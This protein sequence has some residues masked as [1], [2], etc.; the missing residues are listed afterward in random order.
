MNGGIYTQ[1]FWI[2]QIGLGSLLPL[3]L[4][5]GPTGKSRASIATASVLVILGGLAQVYVIVI[6]GQAY[7]IDIYPG[8][9]VLSSSFFDGQVNAYNPTLPEFL[10]G[11]SGFAITL[12][13]TAIAVK[14]LRFLPESLGDEAVTTEEQ[15]EAEAAKAHA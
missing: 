10:L 1:L 13:A 12:V 3:A 11:L 6:G 14:V 15:E 7:P 4:L 9:E 8:Y 2:V 5:Y